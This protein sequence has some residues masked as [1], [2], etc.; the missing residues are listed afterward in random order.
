MDERR[1]RLSTVNTYSATKRALCFSV[2]IPSHSAKEF[3]HTWAQL[4]VSL[5]ALLR[6]WHLEKCVTPLRTPLKT[7]CFF[8]PVYYYLWIQPDGLSQITDPCPGS[9]FSY[10]KNVWWPLMITNDK[11]DYFFPCFYKLQFKI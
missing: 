8:S 5:H 9:T 4:L 3:A 6:E 7:C 11:H 2:L 1:G 10:M